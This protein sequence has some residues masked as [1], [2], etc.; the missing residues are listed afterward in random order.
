[1]GQPR[2]RTPDSEFTR[3]VGRCVLQPLTYVADLYFAALKASSPSFPDV[4]LAARLKDQLSKFK[5]A[6]ED[7][8]LLLCLSHLI[9]RGLT[10]GG[11]A[12]LRDPNFYQAVF[13]DEVQSKESKAF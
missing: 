7:I 10:K 8:D 6:S 5:L 4:P 12:Q 1:M 2:T 13:V 3:V 11:P 9:G